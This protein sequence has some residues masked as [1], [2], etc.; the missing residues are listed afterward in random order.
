MNPS[1]IDTSE[2][3]VDRSVGSLRLAQLQRYG[4]AVLSIGVALGTLLL[5]QDFHFRVPA[6]LL[7]LFVVAIISWYGGIG[8]AVL[9]VVLS[10]ISFYWYFVEP[11]R[12]I[13]IVPSEIPNFITFAAFAGLLS[14]FG[15]MRRRAEAVPRQWGIK[16]PEAEASCI[17]AHGRCADISLRNSRCRDASI[18]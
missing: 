8:P 5:L 6:A 9:A 13:Y 15:T 4:L 2:S 14:W 7:L 12:T 11:V 3:A 17:V 10:I 18:F 1:V 16:R